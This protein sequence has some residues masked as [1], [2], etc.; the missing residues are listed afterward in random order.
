MALADDLKREVEAIFATNWQT[1]EGTK[2]P[3]PEDIKLGNDAVELEAAVLYAD[4]V[5]ST[6]LVSGYKNWFAAEIYKA[7][8]LCACRVIQNNGGVITAFDGDRVM[9]V[10][11]EGNKNTN[12]AKSALKI[13]HCVTEI[14]NPLIKTKFQN[15][16]YQI[17]HCVG[18]DSGKLFV[19]RTGI[20]KYNDLVWV[21]KA[22]NYSAKL[23]ALRDPTRASWITDNVFSKMND[24]AKYSSKKELMW[25][26]FNW[27]EYGISIHG[28][29][30]RWTP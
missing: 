5:E 26:S 27:K 29:N 19:A 13:N 15:T 8:L 17:K 10:Y 1:R 23:C 2:V 16:T 4:L 14:I 9:G 6:E 22:A 11:A 30:W 28:S 25:E 20:R 7:Y 24:E 3:E 18:V 12:A 21:G